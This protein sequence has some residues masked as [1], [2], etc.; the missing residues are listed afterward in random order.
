M[1]EKQTLSV[2][3]QRKL[4]FSG[5]SL[6]QRFPEPTCL[7]CQRLLVQLLVKVLSGE[8]GQEQTHERKD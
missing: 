2:P 5:D 7:E 1:N 8:E 3:A 4:R 6:W